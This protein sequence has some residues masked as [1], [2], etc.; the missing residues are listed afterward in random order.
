MSARAVIPLLLALRTAAAAYGPLPY[1]G[2]E[3]EQYNTASDTY[4]TPHLKWAKPY[5]GGRARV[6]VVAPRWGL[7]E[8]VELTQRVD[9]E[10][11]AFAVASTEQMGVGQ[12]YPGGDEDWEGL[13]Y[14][15][16]NRA[17]ETALT[18]KWDAVI[19]AGIDGRMMP[20]VALGTLLQRVHDEGIGL[21][22]LPQAN[23]R[24]FEALLTHGDPT[25]RDRILRPLPLGALATLRDIRPD[26]LLVVAEFGRG[27]VAHLRFGGGY[28]GC[29][30]ADAVDPVDFEYRLALVAQT[31]LWVAQKEPVA[32]IFGVD[33]NA[34]V[35]AGQ[36]QEIRFDVDGDPGAGMEA[37]ADVLRLGEVDLAEA[38]VCDRLPVTADG[39]GY[40]CTLPLLPEGR[41]FFNLRLGSPAG[42]A[43]WHAGAFSVQSPTGIDSLTTDR[44]LYRRGDPVEGRVWLRGSPPPDATVALTVT[45]G[46]GRL[47]SRLS[48]AA[49][50]GQL[51]FTFPLLD[52][53]HN[54]IILRAR[55]EVDGTPLS[56]ARRE[57]YAPSRDPQDDFLFVM[58]GW[59]E[60]SPNRVTR[61]INQSAWRD[62]HVD[63]VDLHANEANLRAL[64]RANLRPLPYITRYS[65]SGGD[66][67]DA[68]PVRVPSLTDP[69]WRSEERERLLSG[70]RLA[71]QFAPVGYTL[72][73]ENY[74]SEHKHPLRGLDVDFHPSSLQSFR[75]FLRRKY[76]DLDQLNRAWQTSFAS[77]EEVVP[78][79]QVEALRSG[80]YARW[81]D[82]RLHMEHVFAQTHAWAAD[83]IREVDP[84][85]RVGFDGTSPSNSFHGYDFYQM[86]QINGLQNIYDQRD[87]RELLRS[88]A[89]REALTGIWLGSYLAHRSEDH[90]RAF[91]W[92]MLLHGMNSCWYWRLYGD[93][94]YGNIMEALAP[95]L[96]PSYHFAWALD[97][98][99]EIKSGLGKLLLHAERLHDG[100]A[101]HYSPASLHASSL[102]GTMGFV[103][104]AQA[105][106]AALLEDAG[107]QYEFVATPQVEAGAL[108]AGDYRVLV[109]PCSQVLTVAEAGAVRR[110][111]E[112]GGLVI[113]D[114]RPAYLDPHGNPAAAGG[115]DDLFGIA[116]VDGGRAEPAP[117]RLSGALG[118]GALSL[119]LPPRAIDGSVVPRGG[120]SL[121]TEAGAAAVVVHPSG[122]GHTVLLN[123]DITDYA[124]TQ[125][126]PVVFPVPMQGTLRERGQ[127]GPLR[128]LLRA[129]LRLADV[130]PPL[131]MRTEGKELEA[132]EAVFFG[133]G[134]I[135]YLGLLRSHQVADLDPHRTRIQLPERRH[136]Y[137]ARKGEYLGETDRIDALVAPA[138]A[139][140]FTLLPYRVTGLDV[141]APERVARGT[142][143]SLELRV[144]TVGGPPETHVIHLHVTDADG[145]M[146]PEL[147]RNVMLPAGWAVTTL[148]MALNDPVGAWTIG[149][150]DAA[151]GREQQVAFVVQ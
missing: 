26:S 41:Y 99:E 111:V 81:I 29:F 108:E 15:E 139:L 57:I 31:L 11:T 61:L 95:D 33:W 46:F 27:R 51:N 123:F 124:G 17:L 100:I 45:D 149:A 151:T 103:P 145:R 44:E 96:R 43:A 59:G 128:D 47:M 144:L 121:A 75:D 30:T 25:A 69:Q 23:L 102:D 122:Q 76:G 132:T 120:R 5:A 50:Q 28:R 77:W 133:S 34:E 52:V 78:I 135:R 112:G 150:R 147:S 22:V 80:Q 38:L 86:L 12:S 93:T 110:F 20:R 106:F 117:L 89:S 71:R 58:W 92:L 62:L 8:V 14:H 9:L 68:A 87:Q 118:G 13:G 53:L 94:S 101:I 65:Y 85:A 113:A 21:L 63:A 24:G 97:E 32:T 114:A 116:R 49:T 98:I 105:S 54:A 142:P 60:D 48:L 55:L 109:L 79:V 146:R 115:L 136:L 19:V 37:T 18:E 42:Q 84:E 70:A 130:G 140:V 134:D 129:C 88:F 119:D 91:P 67:A 90:Q 2:D 66:P 35:P 4:V 40:R 126:I 127:G 10:A 16:R 6:L 83:A 72:G 74:V 131:S 148:P 82:H 3:N 39:G 125:P 107:F 64:M 36:S 104:Y 1:Y 137:D 73:D 7:R 138:R 56:L 143:L 141:T